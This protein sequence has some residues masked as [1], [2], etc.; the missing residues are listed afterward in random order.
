MGSNN[1]EEWAEIFT[2]IEPDSIEVVP[3]EPLRFNPVPSPPKLLL[4][5]KIKGALLHLG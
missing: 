1:E 5:V 4:K 2:P 3:L